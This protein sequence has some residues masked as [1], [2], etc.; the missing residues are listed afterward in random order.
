LPDLEAA[1]RLES[2]ERRHALAR[3]AR[4]RR[5]NLTARRGYGGD[6]TEGGNDMRTGERSAGTLFLN[7]AVALAIACAALVSDAA[8]VTSLFDRIGIGVDWG[9]HWSASPTQHDV[10][11]DAA[12]GAF[13]AELCLLRNAGFT[14]I[15]MYG[16]NSAT[17]IALLDAVDDFNT[18]KLNCDP[19]RPAA[20]CQGGQ[21]MSVVY[22]AAICG[23]DPRS[24]AWNGTFSDF[25]QVKCYEPGKAEAD[26][27]LFADSLAD[28][29]LKLEV[30]L[31]AAGDKFAK[32]VPLVFVGNE[33]LFSRGVCSAGPT[34]GAACTDNRDCGTGGSCGIAHYCSNA[35]SGAAPP[36]QCTSSATCGAGSCT[37][38][39]N[40]APLEQAFGQVQQVLADRLP[41]GAP[42]AI[43]I[44]L[45]VDL[46]TSGSFGDD[47]SKLMYSRQQLAN[48]LTSKVIAV[49]T[50]PDQWGKVTV[51]ETTQCLSPSFPSCVGPSNAVNGQA[52]LGGCTE[53]P[54]YRDPRTN[55]IAHTI[56]N[57]VELLGHRYYPGFDVMIAETGWHTAG[58]CGVYNDC[59][60]TYSAQDAATY[61]AALYPYVQKH[62]IPLLAFEAFDERTKTCDLPPNVQGEMAE[63]NYGLFGNYCQLKGASAGLL[64]PA[65]AGS[66][67]PNLTALQAL[68]DED[69][70][71]GKSCR[72]QTLA[73]VIGVGSVG[74]CELEPAIACNSGYH[75]ADPT[76]TTPR[77]GRCPSGPNN[78]DNRCVWGF[79]ASKTTVG[80]NPDDPGNDPA[81]GQ[82][83]R[84]GSCAATAAPAGLFLATVDC[85]GQTCG[86]ACWTGQS[87]NAASVFG[88][89]CTDATCACYAAMSP[90]APSV[91]SGAQAVEAPGFV[92]TYGHD[93][94]SF[95]KTRTLRPEVFTGPY[96][97]EVHPIWGDA[98]IGKGW[99]LKV[100]APPGSSEAQPPGPCPANSVVDIGADP[101]NPVIQWTSSW[102]PCSYQ[103]GGVNPV[104]NTLNFPRGF[105]QSIPTWPP[106]SCP[107][108]KCGSGGGTVTVSAVSGK[109]KNV[110]EANDDGTVKITG[111]FTAPTA[112]QLDEAIVTITDLLDEVGGA[113]ELSERPGGAALLPIALVA[114]PGSTSTVAVYETSPGVRP[115]VSVEIKT[116]DS[117]MHAMDF[118]I[119]VDHDSM[120]NAPVE[121]TTGSSQ[122]NLRMSF[123]IDDGSGQPI[124]VAAVLP[125]QCDR[126]ELRVH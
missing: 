48:A 55:K 16:E 107:G 14:S 89:T 15:R 70:S 123:I 62:K 83:L 38:V 3:W 66:P 88:F 42:P 75:L 27:G 117:R 10:R 29:L 12:D 97:I 2:F 63:A 85:A 72:E 65:G 32:H 20:A 4:S 69:P 25:R 41:A 122:A 73:K 40:L 86:A 71:G 114:Q 19:T 24:L 87:C 37:D 106:S 60:A 124:S 94:F 100:S 98:F 74:V 33:I 110:G 46:L 5:R 7:V 79:C 78:S 101:A 96:G 82:C 81:C 6:G 118:T 119:T 57:Y 61:W 11:D 34:P 47:G 112:I 77:D 105:L 17:W 58:V 22:Q 51:G 115:S 44:S 36:V 111:R 28:E 84:A 30:I 9:P 121:C 26:E 31:G 76:H 91:A 43:S 21:C 104:A 99:T 80:C 18:G 23:P 103:V 120:P 35:L 102:V 125:W 1:G 13:P 92:L 8:A 109:A 49:N 52:L 68:L 54:L 50:Y 45:Q 67:G 93:A 95:T 108:G 64:P 90:S 59:T 116:R 126:H 53:N 113:G 56:D 39:T